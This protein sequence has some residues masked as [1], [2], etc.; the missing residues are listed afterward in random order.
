M[1][2]AAALP[3]AS[4][5]TRSMG[6]AA[7]AAR[8]PSGEEGEGRPLPPLSRR[9]AASCAPASPSC[10]ASQVKLLV[11]V[12]FGN[13]IRRGAVQELEIEA[14]PD[15]S[16]RQCKEKV[17]AAAGGAVTA[18]DLLL[19]FGALAAARRCIG[20]CKLG[21]DHEGHNVLNDHQH[22]LP[23]PAHVAPRLKLP[24]HPDTYSPHTPA[25]LPRPQR[26]Q[27]GQAVRER[28]LGGR[29]QASAAP[30]LAAAV[31]GALPPLEADG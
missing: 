21:K 31:G 14:L 27:A 6:R 4:A 8:Q 18:D 2:R 24:S 12:G 23:C 26:P 13:C 1:V 16:V 29:D 20:T 3:A 5:R 9:H 25:S 15:D 19:T 30:V 17:A 10:L 28:P 7:A 22:A 11:Q